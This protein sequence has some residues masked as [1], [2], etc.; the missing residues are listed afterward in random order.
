MND[1][2]SPRRFALRALATGAW[3]AASI[4]LD[5]LRSDPS[6]VRKLGGRPKRALVAALVAAG[7][8]DALFGSPLGRAMTPDQVVR[9]IADIVEVC[10]PAWLLA[11]LVW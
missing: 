8:L 9:M 11:S 7:V 10:F 4:V 2:D 5:R 3:S 1:P 6:G